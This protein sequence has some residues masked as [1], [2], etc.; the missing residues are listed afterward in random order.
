MRARI[1]SRLI[2]IPTLIAG[3]VVVGPINPVGAAGETCNG[4]VATIVGTAGAE[5]LTGTDA[6]DVI[7]GLG[8]NDTINAK[9]GNDVICALAS[10][11]SR[12]QSVSIDGG[13]GTDTAVFS[14]TLAALSSVDL[15][16]G[17]A[18]FGEAG[19]VERPF[20]SI[21]NVTSH[22]ATTNV[23]LGGPLKIIGTTGPNRFKVALGIIEPMGGNDVI[24]GTTPQV[25]AAWV[26]VDYHRAKS[27]VAVDLNTGV[28]TGPSND[29]LTNV[30]AV[31]G[32]RFA[33]TL[34][35][36]DSVNSFDGVVGSDII[37]AR[38]G[39]DEIFTK[40]AGSSI[41]AGDG[42]DYIRAVPGWARL[43]AGAGTNRLSLE[44]SP[45]AVSVD[46]RAQTVVSGGLTD[47][48][49]GV[50]A[51]I[52]SRYDDVV[53]GTDAADFVDGWNGNDRIEGRGGR[54]ILR[55]G[56]GTDTLDGGLGYDQC[57]DDL[58][59]TIRINCEVNVDPD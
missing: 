35:G 44:Q 30:D 28:A 54:D 43:D 3:L 32:T 40:G 18:R 19:D 1:H 58:V 31:I 17:V 15:T 6:A 46:L 48:M 21:E 25:E 50:I 16:L 41:S 24:T 9:G 34:V 29:T 57:V 37:D 10:G 12:T 55:G 11:D 22:L 14:S 23:I 51:I 26:F 13:T 2:V 47:R 42:N 49:S 38:G 36:D 20:L 4:K 45:V 56:K 52:G 59:T 5:V 8:G 7:V 33:D 39:A 53:S 27:G